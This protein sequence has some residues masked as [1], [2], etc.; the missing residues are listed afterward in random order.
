MEGTKGSLR[1]RKRNGRMSGP[2]SIPKVS[3]MAEG[4]G[5]GPEAR[6]CS[7]TRDM[8]WKRAEASRSSVA[9]QRRQGDGIEQRWDGWGSGEVQPASGSGGVVAYDSISP[10]R[11]SPRSQKKNEKET[12]RKVELGELPKASECEWNGWEMENVWKGNKRGRSGSGWDQKRTE[13]T[14][15]EP[16]GF[17]LCT[18]R[19]RRNV[20]G[21]QQTEG[22]TPDAAGAR[23]SGSEA[24]R[25]RPENRRSCSLQEAGAGGVRQQQGGRRNDGSAHWTSQ[26]RPEKETDN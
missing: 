11:L 15:V 13:V 14:R 5:S 25:R 26:E 18:Y 16:T 19:S 21:Y 24:P 3:W 17:G 2:K 20:V 10:L 6:E 22:A 8:G 23:E 1:I 9:W 7:G 12:L 4:F